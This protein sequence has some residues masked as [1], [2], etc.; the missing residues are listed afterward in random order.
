MP[1]DCEFLDGCPFFKGAMADMPEHAELFK[2]LYCRGN[3]RMC[4][5]HMLL[6]AVGKKGV[7]SGLF[8]NQVEAA[9][10]VLSEAKVS[11]GSA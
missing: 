11:N 6:K 7:P 3:Y 4:A 2:T 9:N 8:P 5:I 1:D 10:R